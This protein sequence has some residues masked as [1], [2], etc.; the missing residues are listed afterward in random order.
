MLLHVALC[1]ITI[2]AERGQALQ[3]EAV[4][5]LAAGKAFQVLDDKEAIGSLAQTGVVDA[6]RSTAIAF[7]DDSKPRVPS[8]WKLTPAALRLRSY[9][10][11]GASRSNLTRSGFWV[12]ADSSIKLRARLPTTPSSP[13]TL[14]LVRRNVTAALPPSFSAA[15]VGRKAVEVT[16]DA[17]QDAVLIMDT[18][19]SMEAVAAVE[20]ALSA[21]QLNQVES[22]IVQSGEAYPLS[23]LKAAPFWAAGIN[24]TGQ[25]VQ[26]GDSGLDIDHCMFRDSENAIGEI[27]RK[28][29]AL[30]DLAPDVDALAEHGTHVR[31]SYFCN[32]LLMEA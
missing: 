23:G 2:C 21:V 8:S 5:A 11:E 9:V 22:R 19:A 31:S 1:L 26:I 14:E 3:P 18:L 6:V 13:E 29:R 12:Q 17:L 25:L 15:A 10:H 16:A 32:S 20:P 30:D 24:G 28:I 7:G 4:H 27:H